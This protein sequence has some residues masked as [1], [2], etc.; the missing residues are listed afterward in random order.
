MSY[1]GSNTVGKDE[2]AK[3][4]VKRENGF[5]EKNTKQNLKRNEW[6]RNLKKGKDR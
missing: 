5:N 6:N 3:Y 2:G 1:K 4:K